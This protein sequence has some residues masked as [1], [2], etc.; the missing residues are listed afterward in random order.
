MTSENYCRR[1]CAGAGAVILK[2]AAA[3]K[4][5]RRLNL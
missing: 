1:A 5:R 3:L 4:K 2:I